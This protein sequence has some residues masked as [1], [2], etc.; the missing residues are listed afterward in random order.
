MTKFDSKIDYVSAALT[1]SAVSGATDRSVRPTQK[2]YYQEK[3]MIN[4]DRQDRR[5]VTRPLL[6][7]DCS[8]FESAGA[9]KPKDG[10]FSLNGIKN[11]DSGQVIILNTL[12][13]KLKT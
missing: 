5:R 2:T 6:A 12:M 9:D 4:Y 11:P 10:I 1:K 7:E 3:S 8:F 13:L